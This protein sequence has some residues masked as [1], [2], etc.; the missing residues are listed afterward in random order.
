[1]AARLQEHYDV[2]FIGKDGN[3]AYC[4]TFCFGAKFGEG[5]FQ[6][7]EFSQISCC[8]VFLHQVIVPTNLSLT[9]KIS[10]SM[11][12]RRSTLLKDFKIMVRGNV[13]CRVR[14]NISLVT[15]VEQLI[16]VPGG[17]KTCS[18]FHL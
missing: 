4:N 16:A 15:G 17:G 3:V 13:S 18:L 10:R 6:L 2:L 11:V 9:L 5:S 1:M 12:L 7:M 14:E 8:F